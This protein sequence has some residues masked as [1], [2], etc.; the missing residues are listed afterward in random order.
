MSKAKGK[1][2]KQKGRAGPARRDAQGRA[3]L[4]IQRD[5]YGTPLEM[6]FD[7]PLFEAE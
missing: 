5:E 1:S 4:I 3:H 7:G 6:A 2:K